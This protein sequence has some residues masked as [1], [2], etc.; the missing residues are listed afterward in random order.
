MPAPKPAVAAF[1]GTSM[2]V[3]AMLCCKEQRGLRTLVSLGADSGSAVALALA[4][5]NLAGAINEY[6]ANSVGGTAFYAPCP[7]ALLRGRRRRRPLR[8]RAW[9][10]LSLSLKNAGIAAED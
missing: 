7:L 3:A 9:P 5:R 8:P 10:S 4:G 6:R 1:T 2:G